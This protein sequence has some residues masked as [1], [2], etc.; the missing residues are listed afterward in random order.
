MRF[1][2]LVVKRSLTWAHLKSIGSKI[3][4]RYSESSNFV[5]VLEFDQ[6]GKL[7]P[8]M[9]NARVLFHRI[10]MVSDYVALRSKD[11]RL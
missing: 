5:L 1:I 2:R 3:S 9:F 10:I 11:Q 4:F 7:P 6:N 8:A